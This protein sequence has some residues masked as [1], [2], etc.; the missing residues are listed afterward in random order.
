M[1]AVS[2]RQKRYNCLREELFRNVP[3]NAVNIQEYKE[4][5]SQDQPVKTISRIS[6]RQM[7]RIT[8]LSQAVLQ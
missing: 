4:I 8:T 5:F 3:D 6:K 7:E 1:R 2:D